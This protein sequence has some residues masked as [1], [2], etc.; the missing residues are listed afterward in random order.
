VAGRV[1]F[2]VHV[3]GWRLSSFTTSGFL[4]NINYTIPPLTSSYLDKMIRHK[5]FIITGL[6]ILAVFMGWGKQ[7]GLK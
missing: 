7:K 4:D 6:V 2:E 3:F 1:Y 5:E